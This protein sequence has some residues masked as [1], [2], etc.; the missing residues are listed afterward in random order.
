MSGISTWLGLPDSSASSVSAASSQAVKLSEDIITSGAKL[1]KYQYTV[2]RS[3]KSVKVLA[4]VIQIDLTNPY[5]KLDTMTGTSGQVTTRQS[6]G[7]MVQSTGAVAGVN[8]DVFNTG[9]QGVAMGAS[10][11]DGALVTSPNKL[12]GMYAFYLDSNRVP[13]IDSFTFEG[14]VLAE[15]GSSFPLA[16]INKESYKTEP[17]NAYSHVNAMY[18]YTSAWTS[19]DRPKDSSTTP[20]EVLVEN[21]IVQQI[22][23]GAEISGAIPPDGYIL[24]AHGTAANFVTSHLAVGQHVSSNYQLRTVAG[25]KLVDPASLQMLISGH[26]LLVD[27]GKASAFTRST[28]GVSGSSAVARTAIGYSKDGKTAY[29]ITAEKNDGSSGMTLAELQGFMTG[30]GVWKGLDLDGG[31]S[32]TMI[33][34]PLGETATGLTF[35]TSNGGAT[36]RQVANG[37]GVYTTA[38]QGA[39]KGLTVSGTQTLLIGQEASYSLKGYDTYYNPM[40]TSN[41]TATWKSSNGNVVWTG[42]AFKAVQPGTAL[43][44]AVSGQASASTQV[45]V[46]G[47]DSLGSLSLGAQS[48][49]LQAGATV[50]IAPTAKLKNGQTVEVP[51]S[52]LKWEFTGMQ[53][54]VGG[55]ILT[56]KSITPGAKVAYAVARYDGFSAV[57]SFTAA[58]DKSWED[59]ENT[60]Y[61]IGFTGSPAGVTGQAQVVPSGDA[62]HGKVLQL[63]YDLTGGTGNR[64]A[65]AQLNGTEGRAIPDGA[66]AMSIDVL[67]DS[68]LN[69]LRAEINNNGSTVYVDIAR[70]LDWTG[71]KTV[72][73]D[74]SGLGLASGAKLKR[75]YVVDLEDGQDERAMTGSVSMDNI[76]FTVP[77][78]GDSL[79]PPA[80]MVM[81]IGQKAYTVNGQKKSLDAAPVVK[82]GTT[83]VPI[84]YVMDNFGGTAAWKVDGK[85][86]SVLRGSTM[87]DLQV[88]NKDYILNGQRQTSEVTP[89]IVNNRTLVPI[90]MVSERLGISVKWE[91][92]TKSITLES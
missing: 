1:Q 42:S 84:R 50:A 72:N 92:K 56:V 78:G 14:S 24:R 33:S 73:I 89:L 53:A 51:A 74:L 41:I 91:Q 32:T 76:R 23:V 80:K 71:W 58:G 3:G 22:S 7:G 28:S 75:L 17:D 25:G 66:S 18:I 59:F 65:Y 44:T 55:G 39:L 43:L 67:G 90:R 77:A 82:D 4:D 12:Q 85:R 63:S 52:A 83:Y 8:G 5:V 29:L 15:D 2:T 30:I 16:G 26:T 34:R 70:Q 46:I 10:V 37:I 13:A 47:A 54:S 79:Y 86:I 21:D 62:A 35:T 57:I 61:N 6:V 31:G 9:G 60:A 88:G 36:Q 38:P 45:T 40:D 27:Q 69:W 87:L 68:S 19:P 20:T 64:F 49:A 11:S 48:G 81:T